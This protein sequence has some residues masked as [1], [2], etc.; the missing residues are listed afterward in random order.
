[1]GEVR[2][3]GGR[4][5]IKILLLVHVKRN[6]IQVCC[7]LFELHEGVREG[8]EKEIKG[9]ERGRGELTPRT[10]P[11]NMQ[12]NTKR[13]TQCNTQHTPRN[14]HHAKQHIYV[15]CKCMKSEVSE[16]SGVSEWSEW[17]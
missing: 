9:D 7:H 13:N 1:M 4:Y 2:K 11:C 17:S 6:I 3:E 8:K 10:T 12:R 5:L 14:T 15:T 16:V